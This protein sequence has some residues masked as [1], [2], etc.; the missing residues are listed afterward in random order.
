MK[1]YANISKVSGVDS[2]EYDSAYTYLIV[3]FNDGTILHYPARLN[4]IDQIRSMCVFADLGIGLHRYLTKNKPTYLKGVPAKS[5]TNL[6][7]NEDAVVTKVNYPT[8]TYKNIRWNNGKDWVEIDFKDGT[9]KTYTVESAG[10]RNV[11][12]IIKYAIEGKGLKQYLDENKPTPVE[13][14]IK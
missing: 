12:N 7:E 4:S 3:K 11:I 2:Y 5:E 13:D 6:L 8:Y 14:T 1:K 9:T 10:K